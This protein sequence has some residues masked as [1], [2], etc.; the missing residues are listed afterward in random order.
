MMLVIA[1]FGAYLAI[2]SVLFP[3]VGRSRL[4]NKTFNSAT[5]I[6]STDLQA[7]FKL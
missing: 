7:M 5:F 3:F 4:P 6:A 2:S 1:Q